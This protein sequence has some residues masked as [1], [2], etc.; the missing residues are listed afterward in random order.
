MFMIKTMKVDSI[1]LLQLNPEYL[2]EGASDK[3]SVYSL[4]LVIDWFAVE[5]PGV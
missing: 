2:E 4:D 3:H 5:P 1:L